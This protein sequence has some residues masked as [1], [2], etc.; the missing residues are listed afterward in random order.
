MFRF[1]VRRVFGALVI[2]LII[3]AIT[4]WLFYAVP[5]DPAM[6]SC[7][8]NCTPENLEQIRK[9]LGIDESIVMQYW[10]WLSGIFAGRDYAGYGN[11]EAPCL[12]YSFANNQP[13]YG[14][15]MD[16][17]PLTLSLAFGAAIFF[18]IIGIGA[19]MLAAS[20]QGKFLDK[21]ASSVSL[22]GSSL[23][24]YFVGY[25]AMFFLV[26]ELGILSQPSY[27]PLTDDPAAW[28]SGLLLP[29]LVLSII[30]T[31]NYTRMTR[32][33]MVEQL[34]EDYVR[35]ARAKGLSKRNVFFRFAWRGA[36]GPIVTI[37][38]VDLGVLI[39]GAI[40]TETTFSLQGIGRLAIESVFKSDLPML[41]GVTVLAAGAIVIFNIVV[42]AVYALIDPRIRLA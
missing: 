25:I 20:K 3:S 34:S 31:A 10:H 12:G 14:T 7:G 37:F 36:M 11:C 18:L 27:T 22:L 33:Q 28:V 40:I 1:L 6:M 16:R 39:G 15:I 38:G 24:I 29:W 4:F 41:L 30:F 23:Q 5:R 21:F 42:D 13:V 19:G 9:N 26:G 2:L 17:L 8:K 32:S 35:T